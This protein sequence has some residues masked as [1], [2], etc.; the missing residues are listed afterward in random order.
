MF[1][2]GLT[3]DA[4]SNNSSCVETTKT[5]DSSVVR[6]KWW[7]DKALW[8]G[9]G[10]FTTTH[11]CVKLL[12]EVS[13]IPKCSI[14]L[15]HLPQ[16]FKKCYLKEFQSCRVLPY[17]FG[18]HEDS[19]TICNCLPCVLVALTLPSLCGIGGPY[20]TLELLHRSCSSACLFS[21]CQ[22]SPARL[23]SKSPC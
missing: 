4:K 16:R 20:S 5:P 17:S 1:C 21:P 8:Q 6:N 9:Q 2:G 11:L 18:C 3:T 22:T 14:A 23:G 13:F 12:Q 7:L 15:V 19:F 10:C